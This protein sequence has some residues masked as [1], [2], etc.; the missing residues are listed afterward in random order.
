MNSH[1]YWFI[2][3]PG[4]VST[5]H[6]W[7]TLNYA[8]EGCS[9]N[10]KFNIPNLKVGTLDQLIGISEELSK[11]K[12][13]TYC[14]IRKLVKNFEDVLEEG[15]DKLLENLFVDGKDIHTYICKFQWQAAKYP[16]KQP[17]KVLVDIITKQVSTIENDMKCKMVNY[18]TSKNELTNIDKKSTGSLMTIDLYGLVKSEDFV[19]GS[20][21]LQTVCVVVPKSLSTEWEETYY[22]ITD[23][24][25]PQSSFLITTDE[26]YNL[27]TVTLFKIVLDEFKKRC[28]AKKFIVRDFI[29]DEETLQNNK[30]DR[31]KVFQDVRKQY[32]LLIRWLKINFSELFSAYIHVIA[33]E[34]FVESVLRYGLPVNFQ[35]AVVRPRKG[36]QKKLRSI[37]NGLYHHLDGSGIGPID[38]LDESFALMNLGF[39]EYYPYVYCGIDIDYIFNDS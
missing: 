27:Y 8:T 34:I 31:E 9:D 38:N 26:S 32:Q 5:S 2:S 16:S 12:T 10:Y 14:V 36:C 20:E 7:E 15:K 25:V 28:Q 3:A 13:S 29:Y 1:N 4:D 23:N 37:L 33:L 19:I 21:Y 35:A 17:L 30:G 39:E 11:I 6:T 18:N 24:I 22:K